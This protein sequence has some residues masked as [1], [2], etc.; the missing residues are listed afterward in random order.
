MP[1]II[2]NPPDTGL[3]ETSRVFFC[4][5]RQDQ[6][7]SARPPSEK[8][9]NNLKD[10]GPHKAVEQAIN[11]EDSGAFTE[12]STLHREALKGDVPLHEKQAGVQSIACKQ[13]HQRRRLKIFTS[14]ITIPWWPLSRQHSE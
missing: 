2:S 4:Y 5:N 9:P 14:V 13:T 6:V 12:A 7:E 1:D 3:L 8:Y 11:G 10:Q